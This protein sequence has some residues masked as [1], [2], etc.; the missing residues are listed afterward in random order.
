MRL[1]NDRFNRIS[2]SLVAA[3]PLRQPF[4]FFMSNKKV[5]ARQGFFGVLHGK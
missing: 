5:D 4:I 2:P 1:G 3:L